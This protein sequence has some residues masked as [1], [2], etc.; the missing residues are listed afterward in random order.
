VDDD[1]IPDEVVPCPTRLFM[2]RS[3]LLL[4]DFGTNTQIGECGYMPYRPAECEFKARGQRLRCRYK[5][6]IRD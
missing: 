3:S 1:R 2:Y 4:R 6:A 5:L